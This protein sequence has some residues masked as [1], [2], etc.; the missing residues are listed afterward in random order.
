MKVNDLTASRGS[1]ITRGMHPTG[2]RQFTP[3]LE[4]VHRGSDML[5][6]ACSLPP[7]S[8]YVLGK[9]DYQI[10]NKS[11]IAYCNSLMFKVTEPLP[12][13]FIIN[14]VIYHF[15]DCNCWSSR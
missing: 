1:M 3:G 2:E 12:D 9:P 11:P 13:N 4:S 10:K 14:M 6:Q 5:G 15:T 8:E 7:V